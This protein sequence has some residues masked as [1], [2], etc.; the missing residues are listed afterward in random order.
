MKWIKKEKLSSPLYEKG[1]FYRVNE[2]FDYI[3]DI[4][5]ERI[6]EI[7]KKAITENF[8]INEINCVPTIFFNPY[9]EVQNFI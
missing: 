7:K 5:I 8:I 9:T 3:I 6:E 2:S 4:E 1:I